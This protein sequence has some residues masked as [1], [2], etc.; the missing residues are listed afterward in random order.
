MSVLRTV[1]VREVPVRVHGAERAGERPGQ[2]TA[3]EGVEDEARWLGQRERVSI[4]LTRMRD[5]AI[6]ALAE[7]DRGGVVRDLLDVE[8][9]GVRAALEHT[10]FEEQ[11]IRARDA[12]RL[13]VDVGLEAVGPHLPAERI[14][15]PPRSAALRHRLRIEVE[16]VTA[17][18]QEAE[19][20]R[21]VRRV[22]GCRHRR[23]G[24]KRLGIGGVQQPERVAAGG[25]GVA[26][27]AEVVVPRDE[28]H[29]LRAVGHFERI[30]LTEWPI[31]DHRAARSVEGPANVAVV[32][33]GIEVDESV[34][35]EREV[36]AVGLAG[37]IDRPRDAGDVGR[38]EQSRLERLEHR[39]AL[40]GWHLA[41]GL[42]EPAG[43]S[44]TVPRAGPQ[45]SQAGHEA[46]SDLRRGSGTR[47]AH[48]VDLRSRNSPPRRPVT[49]IRGAG[50]ETMGTTAGRRAPDGKLA[51][52]RAPPTH[53]RGGAK[54]A[55]ARWS[56]RRGRVVTRDRSG[57]A[58]GLVW[59][60]PGR[61]SR[62]L[63]GWAG[64]RL[65]HPRLAC[66]D[67]RCGRASGAREGLHGR[68]PASCLGPSDRTKRS[69][70]YGI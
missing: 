34:A 55:D 36:V 31:G 22:E 28:R 26:V 66:V 53:A 12:H 7:R 13:D 37:R 1:G 52:W 65:G 62:S 41:A 8:R 16:A 60:R 43:A 59:C 5:G 38:H 6:D 61:R 21:R 49:A 23:A 39:L 57:S 54:N 9:E 17:A 15:E 56:G 27:H 19:D 2:A 11:Q 58:K 33:Q 20:V 44:Q 70:P 68:S 50:F 18:R 48:G 69:V 35:V 45:G 64:N 51:R 47:G 10:A 24:G 30:G 42:V 25:V 67:G 3:D 4:D 40:E 46:W 63:L 32:R 29:H 14:V